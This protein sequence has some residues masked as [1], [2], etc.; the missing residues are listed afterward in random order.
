MSK[1]RNHRVKQGECLASLA[2]KAGVPRD[3]IW[4]DAANA[5]LGKQRDPFVLRP[6]DKIA[7]PDPDTKE[8]SGGTDIRHS[9][10]RKLDPT[11]LR[12]RMLENGEPRADVEWTLLDGL[13]VV[14]EGTTAHDGEVETDIDPRVMKLTLQ[15]G[16][17]DDLEQYHLRLGSLDPL[18]TVAGVQARLTNLGIDTGP[19]DDLN[20]PLTEKGV[21]YFQHEHDLVVDGIVGKATRGAL[22]DAY[23]C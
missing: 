12:I 19:I 5:Q 11:K 3:R 17:K 1:S 10:R 16:P 4:D 8:E 22:R 9:F 13:R 14:A 15:F 23:G 20:G 18:K 2:F 21:R 6:R 7:I